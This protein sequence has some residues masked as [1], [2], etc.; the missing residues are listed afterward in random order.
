MKK[1]LFAALAL[2][3]LGLKA[4][5]AP[6][7][8]Y[9]QITTTTSLTPTL[10]TGSINISS[11]SIRNFVASTGTIN[12]VSASSGVINS[13]TASTATINSISGSSATYSAVTATYING[14]APGTITSVTAG[15]GL[16]G[17]GS[18]GGVTLNLN[19]ATT[20]YIQNTTSAQSLSAFNVSTGTVSSGTITSASITTAVIS[21]ATVAGQLMVKGGHFLTQGGTAPSVTGCGTGSPTVTGSD[22]SGDILVGS[23][24]NTSC[25]LVFG[26]AYNS[27]PF[28]ISTN[29]NILVTTD[30]QF[31]SVSSV[32]FGFSTG[33][34]GN[35]VYYNCTARN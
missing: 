2:I 31:V 35:H 33:V 14:N 12:T 4:E 24:S 30:T 7:Y 13:F 11:G 28:C 22:M 6:L 32:T 9:V 21:S 20:S 17:G 19:G 18:S 1:L 15:Y 29:N 8:G 16:I 10:Q 34:G 27:T 23:G 25:A 26:T 3:G 5:A